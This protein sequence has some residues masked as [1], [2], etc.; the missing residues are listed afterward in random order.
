ML[1]F[2][3]FSVWDSILGALSGLVDYI[4]KFLQVEERKEED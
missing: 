3:Q 1:W 4:F 2:M